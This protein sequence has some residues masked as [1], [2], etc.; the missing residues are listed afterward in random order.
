M[1]ATSNIKTG[2]KTWSKIEVVLVVGVNIWHAL[3][4]ILFIDC[5]NN[6]LPL[7]FK[8]NFALWLIIFAIEGIV[9]VLPFVFLHFELFKKNMPQ[10]CYEQHKKIWFY[11]GCI[12][13]FELMMVCCAFLTIF[14]LWKAGN[15]GYE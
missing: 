1:A 13:A 10:S 9:Q 11:I 15:Y 8:V 3:K 7:K 12:Q 14:C 4:L 6:W 2:F 5:I